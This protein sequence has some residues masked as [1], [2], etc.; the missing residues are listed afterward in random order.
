LQFPV[1]RRTDRTPGGRLRLVSV[2]RIDPKKGIEYLL[3]AVRALL[4]R[5]FA[6]EAQIVGAPP[7]HLPEC[8][9]Y[10]HA[11]HEQVATLGLEGA[12]RFC[13]QR[14]SREVR[15]VL[16]ESHVFVAPSVELPN[17]DKDGIPTAVLEA[18]ASGCV[19]VATNAGSIG[20]VIEHG[21][22]GLLVPQ[23]DAAALAAAVER[24]AEDAPLATRLSAAAAARARR[25]FDVAG[26][27]V[28]F[29]ERV[30]DAIGKHGRSAART[31][32]RA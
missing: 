25:E 11:L 18:M 31:M 7:D 4:D 1:I 8:L 22:E 9:A 20:E 14:D 29:H 27:E 10:E 28:V 2:S 13:G 16:E 21:R 15:S 3:D 6:V 5:G 19:I 23:R 12:I 32:A 24:L 26:S 17:G 30:R